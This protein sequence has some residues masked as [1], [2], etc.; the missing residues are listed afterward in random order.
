MDWVKTSEVRG[1]EQMVSNIEKEEGRPEGLVSV[2]TLGMTGVKERFWIGRGVQGVVWRLAR[3][4]ERWH[5]Q[6]YSGQKGP[7]SLRIRDSI[8]YDIYVCELES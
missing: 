3:Q 5:L 2:G 8:R 1:R 7:D 4:G 6:R